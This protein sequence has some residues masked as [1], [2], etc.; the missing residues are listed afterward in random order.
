MVVRAIQNDSN[1]NSGKLSYIGSA[2]VGAVGGYS[3]KWALPI[4]SH[5]KDERYNSELLKIKSKMKQARLDEIELI[6]REALITPGADEFL[7]IHDKGE[8][9]Y[10]EIKK[11]KVSLADKL[12]NLLTRVNDSAIKAKIIG[13]QTVVAF[14]KYIR[15]TWAFV[16]IGTGI[17][18]GS[19]FIHNIYKQASKK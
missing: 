3:L 8:L 19:T 6:R 7:K 1:E 13:T 11:S 4:T 9:L 18:L 2:I 14:T 15:P 12:M 17:A 16:A 10:H 5:E